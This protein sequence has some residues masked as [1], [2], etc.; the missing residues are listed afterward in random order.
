MGEL[1]GGALYKPYFDRSAGMAQTFA[2]VRALVERVA[3]ELNSRSWPLWTLFTYHGNPYA[4]LPHVGETE[5]PTS[6]SKRAGSS[7]F[8]RRIASLLGLRDASEAE[9]ILGEIR[10]RL[11]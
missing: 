3:L 9:E 6:N 4:R 5:T 1:L 8:L 2:E 10:S 7:E 11:A